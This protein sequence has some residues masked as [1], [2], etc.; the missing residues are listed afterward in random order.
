MAVMPSCFSDMQCMTVDRHD[1][2]NG[3][4]PV[5]DV[6]FAKASKHEA[7]KALVD[8]SSGGFGSG[9]LLSTRTQVCLSTHPAILLWM[10]II[11]FLFW[12][13]A[14]FS[15]SLLFTI[16]FGDHPFKLERCS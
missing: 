15:V 4:G 11:L 5:A 8:L 14:C 3:L 13:E 1:L 9:L 16:P 7:A 10:A 6:L 12:A 2:P